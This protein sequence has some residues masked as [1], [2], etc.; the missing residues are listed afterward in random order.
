MIEMNN[1]TS[2][3]PGNN[4]VVIITV[5]DNVPSFIINNQIFTNKKIG[6]SLDYNPHIKTINI[7]DDSANNILEE[8]VLC[9]GLCCILTLIIP[10]M[11]GDLYFGFKEQPCLDQKFG[12]LHIGI[13]KWLLVSGFMLL[14]IIL[15]LIM[16][17]CIIKSNVG[18]CLSI[19]IVLLF[20]FFFIAWT[21]IGAVIFWRYLEPDHLCDDN[22]TV[23]LW[24]RII[25]GLI[26]SACICCGIKSSDTD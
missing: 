14:S 7:D 25:I 17:P 1:S 20:A 15:S 23:Y 12:G 3:A 13:G 22:L 11:V 16:A 5:N 4:D 10:F 18:L 21:I 8:S 9:C 6:T 26:V 2:I 19:T 24:G